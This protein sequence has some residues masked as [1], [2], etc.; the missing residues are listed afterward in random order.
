MEAFLELNDDEL[1][2]YGFKV[3]HIAKMRKTKPQPDEKIGK[4]KEFIVQRNRL[5]TYLQTSRSEIVKS[6]SVIDAIFFTII[7]RH[8]KKIELYLNY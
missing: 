3:G 6:D 2:N 5:L 8:L 7:K 1:K 4:Q